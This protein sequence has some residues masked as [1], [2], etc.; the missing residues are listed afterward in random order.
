MVHDKFWEAI[1]IEMATTAYSS[2]VPTKYLDNFSLTELD[3]FLKLM[4][5]DTLFHA[6]AAYL[7][8]AYC[9][10]GSSLP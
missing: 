4:E 8:R 5:L 7:W 9:R 3:I 10:I 6:A 1:T 2:E